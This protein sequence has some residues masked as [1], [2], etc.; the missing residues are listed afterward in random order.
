MA[1]GYSQSLCVIRSHRKQSGMSLVARAINRLIDASLSLGLK[2]EVQKLQELQ[3]LVS[4][5]GIPVFLQFLQ[6]LHP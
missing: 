2:L 1:H 6:F 4:C 3:K 5:S